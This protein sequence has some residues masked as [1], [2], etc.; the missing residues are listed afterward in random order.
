MEGVNLTIFIDDEF[1]VVLIN[2]FSAEETDIIE[3]A[4]SLEKFVDRM[5]IFSIDLEFLIDIDEFLCLK[6]CFKFLV[7]V[8]LVIEL[9]TGECYD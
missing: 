8:I 5:R 4:I 7:T 2:E 6:F 9:V 3:F 1:C